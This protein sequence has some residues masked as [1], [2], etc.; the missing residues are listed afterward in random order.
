MFSMEAGVTIPG[1]VLRERIQKG[2]PVRVL[3]LDGGGYLGLATAAFIDGIERHFGVSFHSRFDLFCGTS[4]GAIIALGLA[5]GRRGV[6]LMQLYEQL[7]SQVFQQSG[8]GLFAPKYNGT[9]LR[10]A[11]TAEF[12]SATLGDVLAKGKTSLVTAF[13]VT[14][15]TPRLFKTDHS[16]NLTR[17]ASL[18]LV[19]VV[20]A[21]SAAPTYFPLVRV[22]NPYDQIT[23][24][25]CDG[26]VVANHP[27]LL[28]FAEA[29]SELGAKPSQIRVLSIS[30]PRT[31]LG[32]GAARKKA[33]NRGVWGWRKTLASIFID[34]NSRVAHEVLRRIVVSYPDPRPCYER[35]EMANK[36]VIAID[37]ATSEATA[38]LRHLGIS[39]AASNE[40]RVLVNN[41]LS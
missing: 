34:S 35:V 41:I 26:G 5:Y 36:K 17:D 12:G 25:F 37:C 15:G 11:L 30:T 2:D 23:E 7:G 21:S 22:T 38:I 3:S 16:C 14:T 32:E 6:D 28:G 20:M 13:N 31:D 27:A 24:T 8:S 9:G 39:K 18:K 40:V 10:N 33:L 29:L 1:N 19:D 4:T